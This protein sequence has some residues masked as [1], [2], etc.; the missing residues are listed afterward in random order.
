MENLLNNPN[1]IYLA[2][3][4]ITVL[5]ALIWSF[6]LDKNRPPTVKEFIAKLIA[7]GVFITFIF[8]VLVG[9]VYWVFD[10]GYNS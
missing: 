4:S 5:F 9:F 3:I 7:R 8:I 1:T 2:G 6:F 10:V